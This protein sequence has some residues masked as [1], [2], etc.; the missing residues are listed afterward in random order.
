[1]SPEKNR[2][3]LLHPQGTRQDASAPLGLRAL[4]LV[5]LLIAGLGI[6][7]CRAQEPSPFQERLTLLNPTLT[8]ARVEITLL[9][10][11][12]ARA[13]TT[14]CIVPAHS[15]HTIHV[16][17]VIRGDAA[18]LGIVVTSDIPLL[19]E[20]TSYW[21]DGRPV[22]TSGLSI[23][24]S[25]R[26][27]NTWYMSEGYTGSSFDP[28]LSIL[29]PLESSAMVTVRCLTSGGAHDS[30]FDVAVSPRSCRQV[31]LRTTG[32]PRNA[33]LGFSV[34]S[35]SPIAV[36]RQAISDAGGRRGTAGSGSLAAASL[37]R[38]WYF[39]EGS[40]KDRF[41]EFITLANPLKTDATV[42]LRLFSEHGELG[43]KTRVHLRAGA[44]GTVKVNQ[45]VGSRDLDVS[46]A[47][48]S[49]AP[50][51]AERTMY[52]DPG[53]VKWAGAHSALGS[54]SPAL[55]WY[56]A[57]GFTGNDFEEWLTILNPTTSE[58]RVPLRFFGS[59]GKKLQGRLVTVPAR[60]RQ[61]VHLN[62]ISELAGRDFSIHAH[63]DVPIV[64]ERSMYWAAAGEKRIDG[65]C[66]AGSTV[67]SNS[68][69]IPGGR[70]GSPP[71][72]SRRF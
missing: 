7:P 6:T 44:R 68:W 51:V 17:R 9:R 31:R 33:E 36:S 57:E 59:E 37:S 71:R 42:Q 38:S 15:R 13:L 45:I 28:Y 16:N 26:L 72:E 46:V 63:S 40:T 70:I 35:D 10:S 22:D 54:P 34:R 23:L 21:S 53:G 32:V 41:E 65:H 56:F 52:W 55:D 67:L 58:A 11:E 5:L 50:I 69:Y 19:A 29:N 20:R 2:S 27:S 66:S 1:M 43:S 12:S 18:S 24:G 61:N 47:V 62:R 60:S 30:E 4:I 25:P 8:E 64:V 48:Q 14:D 3:A 39:A 49:D